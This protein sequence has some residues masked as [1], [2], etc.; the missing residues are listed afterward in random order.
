[1][2]DIFLSYAREDREIA[3]KAARCLESHG[4]TVWWDTNIQGGAEFAGEIAREL[5]ASRAVI[6]LWSQR[7]ILSEWVRDEASEARQTGK[8]VPARIDDAM[9]PLGFRQ[10]QAIDLSKWNGDSAAPAF[11]G[12]VASA[13]TIMG[14]PAPPA[15]RPKAK[16][17][18]RFGRAPLFAAIGAVA[19]AAVVAATVFLRAPTP[20]GGV[21]VEAARPLT[22]DAA[23]FA[24]GFSAALLRDFTEANVDASAT[25]KRPEFKVRSSVGVESGKFVVDVSAETAKGRAL[26]SQRYRQ[27]ATE[28]GPFQEFAASR[29]AG[30]I[31]CAL[32]KRKS[33]HARLDD[34]QFGLLLAYCTAWGSDDLPARYAA[35]LKLVEAAPGLALAH[36]ELAASA[37]PMSMSARSDTERLKYRDQSRLAAEKALE[38]DPEHGLAHTVLG[39]AWRT[40][41]DTVKAMEHWEKGLEF[42]PGEPGPYMTM[43]WQLTEVGRVD[44]AIDIIQRAMGRFPDDA[45]FPNALAR[46][47]SAKGWTEEALKAAELARAIDPASAAHS[48]FVLFDEIFTGSV[49]D[50]RKMLPEAA[51]ARRIGEA[52]VPCFERFL[53]ARAAKSAAE[54]ATAIAAMKAVCRG[55]KFQAQ[56]FAALGEADE[57]FVH[58]NAYYDAP[59]WRSRTVLYGREVQGLRAD[60]R[61][62]ALAAK[63]DLVRYWMTSGRWPDFCADT[64]APVDC[65]RLAQEASIVA[66]SVQ[67]SK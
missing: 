12:L 42:D 51:A 22:E 46:S 32:R 11:E 20:N 59:D 52:E 23:A 67:A 18:P 31:T 24:E 44:A 19:V 54:R 4:L 40:R 2:A 41:G 47:Y 25:S 48:S 45:Y 5:A 26:W 37:G 27:D 53:D 50:G 6:V 64:Q 30:A 63:L 9:P 21:L 10:R 3:A 33:A 60:P 62:W 35:A 17:R 8:L 61:F 57:A 43:E 39:H 14:T 55:R 66:A 13:R 34:A 36:A 1:L 7:S 65:K 15:E 16:P 38:I 28:A 29:G 58:L 56:M 49:E